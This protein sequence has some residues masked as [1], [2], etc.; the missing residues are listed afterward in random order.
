MAAHGPSPK[1]RKHSTP[2]DPSSSRTRGAPSAATAIP[3]R[4]VKVRILVPAAFLALALLGPP[5]TAG[6]APAA[7]A[8]ALLGAIE[9]VRPSARHSTRCAVVASVSGAALIALLV[10]GASQALTQSVLGIGVILAGVS[11]VFR[12]VEGGRWVT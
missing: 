5:F 9:S 4:S 8:F 11:V 2:A 6:F 12:V 10:G 1:E 3:P 7:A